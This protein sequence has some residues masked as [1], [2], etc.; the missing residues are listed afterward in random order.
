MADILGRSMCTIWSPDRHLIG[1]SGVILTMGPLHASVFGQAGWSKIATRNAIFQATLM[2]GGNGGK[3]R[4]K[5]QAPEALT[6]VVAGGHGGIYSMLMT[7][8]ADYMETN[9]VTRLVE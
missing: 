1:T 2:P 4:R 8:I 7:G 3:P 5:F 9:M 6:I